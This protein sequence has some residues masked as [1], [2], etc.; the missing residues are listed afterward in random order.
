MSSLDNIQELVK[1]LGAFVQ[2][3]GFGMEAFCGVARRFNEM[4]DQLQEI[5]SNLNKM[6]R[7]YKFSTGDENL[8]Y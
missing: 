1:Q 6:N 5:Y 2:L 4:E 7:I 3:G 8:P